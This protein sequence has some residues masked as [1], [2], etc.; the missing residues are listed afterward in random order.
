MWT[1]TEERSLF[2]RVS[3]SGQDVKKKPKLLALTNDIRKQMFLQVDMEINRRW[4][5]AA[6]LPEL[7]ELVADVKQ[8]DALDG[9]SMDR[10][11]ME[12]NMDECC[13]AQLA[14]KNIK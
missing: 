1:G 13:E 10:R 8:T 4:R 12:E 2:V 9:W 7:L 14:E 11:Q 5:L 6:Q 3:E